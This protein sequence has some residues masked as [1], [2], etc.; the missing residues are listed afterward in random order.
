MPHPADSLPSDTLPASAQILHMSFTALVI[1]RAVYVAA[2]LGIPDLLQDQQLQSEELAQATGMQPGALYRLLR[3]LSS[4]GIVSEFPEHRFALTPV[5]RVLRSDVPGS[6]RA[7]VVFC[8]EPFYLQ[9]WQEILYSIQTGKP[10]WDKV[11]GMAVFDYYRQHPEDARIFDEAMTSLSWAEA[12]A[13][14][15]AYDFARF[16]TL[17]DVGGGHGTLLMTILHAHPQ[18]HGILFDQPQVVEGARSRMTS[19]GL[20]SRCDVVAGDFFQAVP[21]GGDAYM[22]KSI[23]HDWDDEYSV[24]LLKNCRQVIPAEGRLLVIETVVPP[25]GEAHYAKYQDLE[26]LVMLGSQ[27]RT[28]EEYAALFTRAQ[29]KLV[30]VVPTQEPLSIVEAVPV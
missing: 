23:I 30:G 14:V 15:R 1:A 11:H 12:H 25:P 13:V 26:M 4:A 19:E 27:E 6:M 22:L 29:F 8:G 17:V 2:K 7:L 16:R 10:A 20:A 28:V 24:A 9:A 3:A 18:L 5:G 21:Q